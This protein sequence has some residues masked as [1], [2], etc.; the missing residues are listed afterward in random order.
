MC[1]EGWLMM[2]GGGRCSDFISSA[3]EKAAA[4]SA[5]VFV[6]GFPGKMGLCPICQEGMIWVGMVFLLAV[7]LCISIV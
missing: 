4:L 1:N 5:R 2:I 6:R 3:V 7:I